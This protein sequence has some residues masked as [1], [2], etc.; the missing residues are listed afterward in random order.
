MPALPI[1]TRCYS[2]RLAVLQALL[3]EI[4][5]HRQ[6]PECTSE[7]ADCFD[8]EARRLQASIWA[9]HAEVEQD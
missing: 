2:N 9:M 1:T 3:V 8:L 7:L 4:L 5:A 6:D